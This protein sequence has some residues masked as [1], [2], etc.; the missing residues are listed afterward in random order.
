[1]NAP[2]EKIMFSWCS[3]AIFFQSVVLCMIETQ[4]LMAVSDFSGFFSRNH[5]LEGGFIFQW[6]VVFLLGDAPVL[7]SVGWEGAPAM[8]GARGALVIS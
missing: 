4:V 7:C 3:F 6:G 1:M 8:H 2:S 5:F